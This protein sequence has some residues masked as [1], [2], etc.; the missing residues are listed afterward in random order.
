MD[1]LLCISALFLVLS[2]YE[3]HRTPWLILC[4]MSFALWVNVQ[5]CDVEGVVLYWHRALIVTAAGVLLLKNASVLAFYQAIVLLATLVTYAALAY[6]VAHGRHI[7][8]Y[9]NYEAFIYGLVGCQLLG[10]FPTL[11]AAYRDFNSSR[12]AGLVNIQRYNRT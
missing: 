4:V 8:I 5:L 11:W 1:Y 3:K 7:L 2:K 12:R 10:I 6:D 9:N